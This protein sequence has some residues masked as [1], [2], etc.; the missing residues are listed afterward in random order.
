MESATSRY[1]NNRYHKMEP[2]VIRTR[3]HQAEVHDEYSQGYENNDGDTDDDDTDYDDRQTYGQGSYKTPKAHRQND[4]DE[5]HNGNKYYYVDENNIPTHEAD[6]SSETSSVSQPDLRDYV[7]YNN[8]LDPNHPAF[9]KETNFVTTEVPDTVGAGK[10]A[11]FDEDTSVSSSVMSE[12][13]KKK[14]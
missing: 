14:I 4:R 5:P 12:Y 1:A 6:S 2:D 9:Q 11:R 3:H 13:E 8:P 7:D 10:G